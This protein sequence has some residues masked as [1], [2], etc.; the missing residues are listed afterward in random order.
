M[1]EQ[2][3]HFSDAEKQLVL[4]SFN[5]DDQAQLAQLIALCI[6]CGNY[7]LP[8]KKSLH[9]T[10]QDNY[11]INL[12]KFTSSF[13]SLIIEHELWKASQRDFFASRRLG[14]RF[15]SL[16][17][18]T[19]LLPKGFI[20]EPDFLIKGKTENGPVRSVMELCAENDE[21]I[22][23]IGNG[24]IGK[25]TFLHQLMTEAY[26]QKVLSD[27]G[28]DVLQPLPYQSGLPVPFFIELNRCPKNIDTWYEDSLH[29]TNFI[30]RYVAQMMENH[31][32]LTSVSHETLDKIEKEFQ[33]IPAKGKPRYLLLLDG[34]NEVT[35]SQ[36][37]LYPYLFK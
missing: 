25:T 6:I 2:D 32:S 16:N 10:N 13:G 20:A 8:G 26:A 36:G 15:S 9:M 22:A 7:N 29:K 5:P 23:V 27:S 17:I 37:A 11:G 31:A 12:T 24:G 4:S 21:H 34:F 14:G 28:N 30:T 33:K 3:T 19:Q 1:I 35:A 18:I